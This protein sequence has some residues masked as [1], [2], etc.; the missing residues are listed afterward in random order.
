MGK[1]KRIF[2]VVI[3]LMA[4]GIVAWAIIQAWEPHYRG[5]ALG[6]WLKG[7]DNSVVFLGATRH[8]D[9]D[10]AIYQMGT[11]ALP[12]LTKMARAKD[13]TLKQ[14]ITKSFAKLDIYRIGFTPAIRIRIRAYCGLRALGPKAKGAIPLLAETLDAK[15]TLIFKGQAAHALANIGL[16][17][18]KPL[19]TA[20]TNRDWEVRKAVAFALGDYAED[21][22]RWWSF[23]PPSNDEQAAA[24]GLVI[25]VLLELLNDAN[26]EVRS[27][28][29]VSLGKI[30]KQ[31]DQCVPQL[32]KV[33]KDRQDSNRGSIPSTLRKFGNAARVAVPALIYA[34]DDPN[35]HTSQEAYRVLREID[36]E[37]AAKTGVK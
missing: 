10:D 2:L 17:G 24:E 22:R 20:L 15:E 18:I 30:H 32:A 1:K 7:Y 5:R 3:C 25:P 27:G 16:D 12:Y 37:A 36:P 19:Q 26:G 11:N 9:V 21:E 23:E 29:I 31:P 8:R 34:L 13:S 14:K 28:A 4:V 35:S 33:L 6:I